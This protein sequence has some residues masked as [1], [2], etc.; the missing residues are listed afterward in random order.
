M[1]LVGFV[2]EKCDSYEITHYIIREMNIFIFGKMHEPGAGGNPVI[3]TYLL[4]ML[5]YDRKISKMS[6]HS[7]LESCVFN[8]TDF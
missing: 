2:L 4:I 7:E 3:M 1:F 5:I 8:N 6:S